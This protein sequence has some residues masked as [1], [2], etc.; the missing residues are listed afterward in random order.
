LRGSSCCTGDARSASPD[1]CRLTLPLN[2][3]LSQ[4]FSR[5][6]HELI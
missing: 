5:T 1:V 4:T 2:I 6:V 3:P